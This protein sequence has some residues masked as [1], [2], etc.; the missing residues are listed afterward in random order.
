MVVGAGQEP[1]FESG[2]LGSLP[3]S[4]F[5]ALVQEEADGTLWAKCASADGAHALFSR[6]RKVRLVWPAE[7]VPHPRR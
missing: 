5:A 2:S 3:E 7:T 1:S 4:E 6:I